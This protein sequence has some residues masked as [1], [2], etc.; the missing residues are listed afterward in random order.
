[1]QKL[2]NIIM[3]TQKNKELSP[4]QE[5]IVAYGG[6]AVVNSKPNKAAGMIFKLSFLPAILVVLASLIGMFTG[7]RFFKGNA[8]GITG[9]LVSLISYGH[10]L[11]IVPVLPACLIYQMAYGVAIVLK[12]RTKWSYKK[13]TVLLAVIGIVLLG[14]VTVYSNWWE[15]SQ[16][17]EKKNAVRFYNSADEKI[18]YNLNEQNLDGILGVK[19]Q[20]TSCILI[21]RENKE[22]GFMVN[23]TVDEF[24]SYKFDK[25]GQDEQQELDELF[26]QA[27]FALKDGGKL[28][29][30]YPKKSYEHR[31]CALLWITG[32]GEKYCKTEIDDVFLDLRSQ[33][34]KDFVPDTKYKDYEHAEMK[35]ADSFKSSADEIIYYN[36]ERNKDNC[37]LINRENKEIGFIVNGYNWQRF[38]YYTLEPFEQVSERW[39]D[40]H[41]VQAEFTLKDGGKLISFSTT[42][43]YDE[44]MTYAL[45]WITGSGEKYYK[46]FTSVAFL[47]L[48]SQGDK[49]IEHGIKYKDYKTE[50]REK[51][52]SE[53]ER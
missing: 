14:A 15:F 29:S 43:K 49:K 32:S 10:A 33:G 42:N 19:Q 6:Q 41:F 12:R 37:L 7:V 18:D 52:D 46:H 3:K 25:C 38:Q 45:L 27:E 8:Y 4:V 16:Y 28:I 20:Q 13:I 44:D 34:D 30:F 11:C 21:D 47:G 51:S 48:E 53:N 36:R 22:V 24:Y 35:S 26:I 5:Q 31:T 1:M 40:E 23:G 9:F 2:R 17:Y 50:M 39:L